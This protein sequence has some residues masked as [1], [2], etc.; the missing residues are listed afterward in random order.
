MLHAIM[1]GT[2][3]AGDLN[4]EQEQS[5]EAA[6]ECLQ[7]GIQAFF[8][9]DAPISR[10]SEV[11]LMLRKALAPV[12]SGHC[13]ELYSTQRAALVVDYKFGRIPVDSAEVNLQL[14]AYAVS[15]W[16]KTGVPRVGVAIV[17]PRI[18]RERRLTI[19][20]YDGAILLDARNE[21][22]G[23]I[24]AASEPGAVRVAGEAQC[25]YCP[26][27]IHCAEATQV[28]P[29]MAQM[30]IHTPGDM[31][32][33]VTLEALL[34]KCGLAEKVIGEIK[35]EAK[36]R[37][38]ENPEI[39]EGRWKLKPGA[40][41]STITGIPILFGR[42][43]DQGWTSIDLADICSVTKTALEAKARMV[44]GLIGKKLEEWIKMNLTGVVEL[45]EKA[46][47]LERGQV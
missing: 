5:L 6:R 47:S 27:K 28:V 38:S 34:D 19:A 42:L 2:D 13:D 25:R 4:A 18:E 1:T 30:T 43:A 29:E 8:C 15:V 36:R 14:R 11:A 17:Q 21:I 31:V 32:D 44:T 10:Q 9:D 26:A 45:K 40:K 12:L 22:Y 37:L 41:Q 7:S 33:T 3:N 35:A 20:E 16:Q 24:D 46:P 39:F 23:I